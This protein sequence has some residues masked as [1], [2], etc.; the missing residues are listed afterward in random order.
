MAKTL[1]GKLAAAGLRF[2]LIASRF[3]DFIVGRLLEGAIEHALGD[4]LLAVEHQVVHELGQD[5]VAILGVRQDFA[6][7]GGVTTGHL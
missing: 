7:L 2:G 5:A 6:L 1:E 4:G 3:N